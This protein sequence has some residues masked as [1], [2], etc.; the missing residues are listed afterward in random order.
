MIRNKKISPHL[1]SQF[2]TH[3]L[4]LTAFST[5]VHC[6][7]CIADFSLAC[8]L[9]KASNSFSCFRLAF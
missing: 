6:C 2:V 7:F 8:R 1:M 4:P 5:D 3:S 9:R